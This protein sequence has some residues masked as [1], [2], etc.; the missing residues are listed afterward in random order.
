MTFLGAQ[1]YVSYIKD[2]F[3]ARAKLNIAPLAV[4]DGHLKG[5][6]LKGTFLGHK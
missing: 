3:K 5:C 6:M 4:G 2:S 1:P